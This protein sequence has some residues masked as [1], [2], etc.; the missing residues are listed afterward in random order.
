MKNS[1]FQGYVSSFLPRDHFVRERLV[2]D[3]P[4]VHQRNRD[5]NDKRGE[6]FGVE[7]K[8]IRLDEVAEVSRQKRAALLLLKG[9]Q[10]RLELV[11][12]VRLA[13]QVALDLAKLFAYKKDS[14]QHVIPA[15][16]MWIPYSNTH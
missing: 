4:I 1:L 8:L 9:L 13:L 12:G 16:H 7:N 2:L 5:D 3:P 11:V 6:I 14:P 10:R 15:R